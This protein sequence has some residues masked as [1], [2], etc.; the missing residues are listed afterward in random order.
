MRHLLTVAPLALLTL[1]P[2]CP[3]VIDPVMCTADFRFGISVQVQD[4]VTGAW[5]GS[6]A[7]LIARD[8]AYVDSVTGPFG[9]PD[10]D[11]AALAT[12]GERAG[13]YDLVVR[14]DGYRP[15]SRTGVKVEAD[16][17]HVHPV[18]ILARMQP[19]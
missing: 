18:S 14:H 19:L 15:W 11:D 16:E 5:I 9:R 8:G 4:S 3:A 10:A 7:T 12:A 17:C 13:T 2:G 6:G 1:L